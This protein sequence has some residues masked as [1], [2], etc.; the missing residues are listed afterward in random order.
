MRSSMS[1]KI[2]LS[3]FFFAS[4]VLAQAT[5]PHIDGQCKKPVQNLTMHGNSIDVSYYATQ[6]GWPSFSS[7]VDPTL[8]GAEAPAPATRYKV[9]WNVAQPGPGYRVAPMTPYSQ[10]FYGAWPPQLQPGNVILTAENASCYFTSIPVS[11]TLS[12]RT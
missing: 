5:V 3:A 12:P 9:Y 10:T 2:A 1:M 11:T 7:Y 8:P 4:S 6:N